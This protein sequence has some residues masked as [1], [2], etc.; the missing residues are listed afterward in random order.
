MCIAGA[1][2]KFESNFPPSNPIKGESDL[3]KMEIFGFKLI[4]GI[5]WGFS[6]WY[7]KQQF[8]D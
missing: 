2:G 7:C 3:K 5:D 1:S 4:R 6:V 8:I